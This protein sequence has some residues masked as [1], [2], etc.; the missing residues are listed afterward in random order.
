[1]RGQVGGALAASGLF[2]GGEFSELRVGPA[3]TDPAGAGQPRVAAVRRALGEA[4]ATV[5]AVRDG[6][7][8]TGPAPT[9]A[10]VQALVDGPGVTCR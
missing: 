3:V 1:M 4:L 8:S 2:D 5:L 6:A 10:Q 7:P 9:Y